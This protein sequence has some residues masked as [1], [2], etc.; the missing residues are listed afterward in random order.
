[1]GARIKEENLTGIVGVEMWWR[2]IAVIDL[3]PQLAFRHAKRQGPA[4]IPCAE[5]PS[6]SVPKIGREDI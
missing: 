5:T 4:L 6:G 2:I 3:N 1:L